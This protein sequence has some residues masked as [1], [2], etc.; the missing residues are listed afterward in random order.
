[1]TLVDSH[2]TSDPWDLRRAMPH[3]PPHLPID[4]TKPDRVCNAGEEESQ[5]RY[6]F[7]WGGGS[8]V[9]C[10]HQQGA[11]IAARAGSTQD[12]H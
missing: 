6:G 11:T 8:R 2:I 5:P 3:L 9:S 4:Q 10:A 7:K 1:M 12:F